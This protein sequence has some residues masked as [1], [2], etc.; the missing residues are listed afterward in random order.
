MIETHMPNKNLHIEAIPAFEDNYI[1]L[2]HNNRDAVVID[3]GDAVPVLKTL[4]SKSLNL[5][6][7]LI[8]HHHHD[9]IDGVEQLLKQYAAEVFTPS[10]GQYDFKHTP[11]QDGDSVDLTPLNL[12]LT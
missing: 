10:Y 2:L 1:W 6:S 11:L 5:I 4:K 3:P 9:H 12:S 7:I 8:T